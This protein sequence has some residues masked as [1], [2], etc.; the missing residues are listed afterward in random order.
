MYRSPE[1][2]HMCLYNEQNERLYINASERNRFL[3]ATNGQPLHIRAFCLT[4]LYT[5]CRLSE[6]RELTSHSLQEI[7]QRIA[8]RS[9]KK[10][11]QHHIREIPVPA[12]LCQSLNTHAA[13]TENVATSV[14]QEHTSKNQ[15]NKTYSGETEKVPITSPIWL[16]QSVAGDM[17][18]RITAYR[19]VKMVMYEAGIIGPQ[20]CPK[21]LRH[22][23]AIHAIGCGIQLNML[24]KWMGHA[25]IET[26]AIYA[27]AVGAEELEMARK[28]W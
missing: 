14:Q 24:Q 17:V 4:L 3:K 12:T 13:R 19:W 2:S 6:A 23:Y 27:N 11:N 18:D 26:T 7:E 20:A 9:L 28:M 1:Q 22:A 15:N 5:G 10:R 21:G 8:I 25:D 16:W